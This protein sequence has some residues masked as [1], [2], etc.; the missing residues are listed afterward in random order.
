MSI[1]TMLEGAS[2]VSMEVNQRIPQIAQNQVNLFI[3]VGKET[4]LYCLPDDLAHADG[5]YDENFSVL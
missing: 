5:F 1:S 4:N 2:T 3:H